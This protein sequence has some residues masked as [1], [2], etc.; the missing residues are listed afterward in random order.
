MRKTPARREAAGGIVSE[1]SPRQPS[2]RLGEIAHFVKDRRVDG[3]EWRGIGEQRLALRLGPLI[4]PVEVAFGAED[5]QQRSFR[6]DCQMQYLD[7]TLGAAHHGS[8]RPQRCVQHQHIAS[9]D[10]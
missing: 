8:D 7:H 2:E 4:N 5:H 10:T 1:P 6:P 9:M 3:I